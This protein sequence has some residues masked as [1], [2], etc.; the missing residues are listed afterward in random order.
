LLG[1]VVRLDKYKYWE[2]NMGEMNEED[3]DMKGINS[4]RMGV[5]EIF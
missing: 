2:R 4:R 1:L 5:R 3:K